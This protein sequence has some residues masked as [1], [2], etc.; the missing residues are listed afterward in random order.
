MKRKANWVQLGLDPQFQDN[1]GCDE[2]RELDL[3]LVDPRHSLFR[4]FQAGDEQGFPALSQGHLIFIPDG[5]VSK[6]VMKLEG[7][8]LSIPWP[9]SL[10]INLK[11]EGEGRLDPGLD[12]LV[13][14]FRKTILNRETHFPCAV[15]LLHADILNQCLFGESGQRKGQ[16]QKEGET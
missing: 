7:A 12:G 3:R 8:Y 10:L 15:G 1:A 16:N 6:A 14:F 13:H 5:V 4:L 9:I 2:G 11:I